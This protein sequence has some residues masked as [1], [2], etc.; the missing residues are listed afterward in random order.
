MD[1]SASTGKNRALFGLTE[2][3]SYSFKY[4]YGI[5]PAIGFIVSIIIA[6]K[7]RIKE[8]ALVAVLISLA[9]IIISVFSIWRM[10]I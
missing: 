1:Y 6:I 5:P 7:D 8:L 9:A 3:L 2:L 4:Y 10:F